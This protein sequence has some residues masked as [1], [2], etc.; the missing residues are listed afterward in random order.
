MTEYL[1]VAVNIIP[2]SRVREMA[3]RTSGFDVLRGVKRE[4][5]I[6]A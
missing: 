6:V 1:W 2:S 3:G 4:R 5:V